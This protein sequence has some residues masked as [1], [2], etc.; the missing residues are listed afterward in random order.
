[1]FQLLRSPVH[2]DDVDTVPHRLSLEVFTPLQIG[3]QVVPQAPVRGRD[4]L[5]R[6]IRRGCT[7]APQFSWLLSLV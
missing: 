5:W 6:L 4:A 2:R 1:M 7:P 3:D